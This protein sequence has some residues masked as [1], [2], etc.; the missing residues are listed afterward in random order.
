MLG[1]STKEIWV[2]EALAVLFLAIPL[3]RTFIDK[4]RALDG[5]IWLPPVALGILVGIFPAYGFRLE[6]LPILIFALF[7]NLANLAS[8]I[9]SKVSRVND[10]F[11]EIYP[12]RTIFALVLLIAVSVPMFAFSPQVYTR[13]E[14]ETEGVRSLSVPGG[15]LG[16]D[17]V[18]RIYGPVEANRPLVF[19]VP[20]EIG[21]AASVEL[22]CESLQEKGFTVV[23][24]FR[25]NFDT[26]FIDENGRRRA[27]PTRLLRYWRISRRATATASANERGRALENARRSDLEFLL[28]RL[29]A[30]LEL[31]GRDELPP[32]LFVG[33]GAG[34][35]ALAYM[36][37]ENGALTQ[38]SNSLG[39]IAIE[40]HLWSSYTNEARIIEPLTD[41]GRIA[42]IRI[43]IANLFRNMGSQRVNRAGPLPET[44]LPVLYLVSGRALGTGRWQ[45]TY[46][47][48]FDALNASDGHVALAAIKSAGP[49]DYQDY[50]LTQPML[51]FFFPGL[52]NTGRN[53]NPIGNTAGII[54]NFAIF[55]LEDRA[56]NIFTGA[57]ENYLAETEAEETRWGTPARQEVNIPPRSYIQGTLH[58]ESKGMPALRL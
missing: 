47:A 20:P 43:N 38:H 11:Q 7:Y 9:A 5:I 29:P 25:R 12:F 23:T 46:Q 13:H 6:V 42:R 33:Y 27:F 16:T 56:K 45:S 19:I 18:L 51:S 39:V 36:A 2:P 58:I 57:Y 10:P 48:V 3:L 24:Y 21:S 31:T 8:F 49:L 37:G 32:I 4:L 28:P 50:P 26:L 44:G 55:L 30:L 41:A 34:G 22:V 15:F 53:E 40:S 1:M 52:R 54:G 35:S 14:R 17:Y